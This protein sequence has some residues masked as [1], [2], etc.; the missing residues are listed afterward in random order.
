MSDVIESKE[1]SATT[2]TFGQFEVYELVKIRG[3]SNGMI[4]KIENGLFTLLTNLGRCVTVHY[5]EL[6]YVIASTRMSQQR[7]G[8]RQTGLD[9]FGNEIQQDDMV[10]VVAEKSLWYGKI[11]NVRHVFL[12]TVWLEAKDVLE[13][14]GFFVLTRSEVW[15]VGGD[16]HQADMSLESYEKPVKKTLDAMELQLGAVADTNAKKQR[17]KE[18]DMLSLVGKRVRIDKGYYKGFLGVITA[19]HGDQVRVEMHTGEMGL[20]V[21]LNDVKE[22]GIHD[23]LATKEQVETRMRIDAVQ[24]KVVGEAKPGDNF[25]DIERYSDAGTEVPSA[26]DWQTNYSS[27]MS[28]ASKPRSLAPSSSRSRAGSLAGSLPGS[29][30]GSLTS[31]GSRKPPSKRRRLGA[32]SVASGGTAM[33]TRNLLAHQRALTQPEHLDAEPKKLSASYQWWMVQNSVANWVV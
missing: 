3:T 7:K 19:I 15:L 32:D 12:D 4:L 24:K 31:T 33:S 17:R 13:N 20:T 8:R 5:A 10:R 23:A 18:R 25:M 28:G 1:M 26:A 9:K 6:Q 16:K 30:A 21:P 11:A 14:M 2:P 29:L 22:V 27:Q